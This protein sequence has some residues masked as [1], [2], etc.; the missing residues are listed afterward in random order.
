MLKLNELGVNL[1]IK[2]AKDLYSY[3]DNYDLIIWKKDSSG[4]T[5]VKGLFRKNSWGIAEKVSI[6]NNGVWELPKKYVKYFK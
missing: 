1:F 4:F 2:R 6:N 3:W 5:N